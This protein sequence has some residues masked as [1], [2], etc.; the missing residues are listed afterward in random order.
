MEQA[1]RPYEIYATAV[2]RDPT[3]FVSW[4]KLLAIVEDGEMGERVSEAF[5]GFLAKF[6][7]CFGYWCKYADMQPRLW[8]GLGQDQI[9]GR[10]TA[11]YERAVRAVP[12]SVELWKSYCGHL[13]ASPLRLDANYVERLRETYER[14][15]F[16]VG[17]D[18]Q[19]AALWD[20]FL[21]F[22]A[23]NGSP[24]TVCRLYRRMVGEESTGRTD[25]LWRRFK[26]LCSSFRTSELV[27]GDEAR[28]LLLR[29]RTAKKL[30][31]VDDSRGSL[32]AGYTELAEQQQMEQMLA[33]AEAAKNESIQRRL[34]RQP[35][36]AGVRR[37]YFHVKP[38][39]EA[40]LQN[41]RDYLGRE[42]ERAKGASGREELERAQTDVER[43]FERCLV[44]CALYAEFWIKYAY[45]TRGSRGIEA[46]VTV[47]ER[48]ATVYLPKRV[49]I[50]ECY[51]LLLEAARRIGEARAVY[52]AIFERTL[53]DPAQRASCAV[54]RANFERRQ[55]NRA[56]VLDAYRDT[57]E[58]AEPG[59]EAVAAH[60]ARYLVRVANDLGAART[61]LDSAYVRA[62]CS[63]S[64][65]AIPQ[66]NAVPTGRSLDCASPARA[67][68]V[69]RRQAQ[70]CS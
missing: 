13:K 67:L 42:I 64:A 24:E 44:P 36:E 9:L 43:L 39:D 30:E 31:A 12:L 63:P 26:L 10:T 57:L 60:A 33:E 14:A 29:Y 46:A 23:D 35:F 27:S 17:R 20:S 22:E 45:W 37:W 54:A 5:E 40:Q 68:Q 15:V 16:S 55:H 51:A 11:I 53:A 32:L 59:F 41:W 56:N 65:N 28:E 6:P 8:S 2:A 47:I 19:A 7:L 49:D 34:E 1:T 4:S 18:A 38:L 61:L 50:M 70:R 21:E 52:S 48:A 3:D 69:A 25:E 66:A 62:P 58:R